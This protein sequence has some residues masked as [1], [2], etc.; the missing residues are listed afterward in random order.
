MGTNPQTGLNG[1]ARYL[2]SD[3]GVPCEGKVW[4]LHPVKGIIQS[5]FPNLMA[6]DIAQTQDS[7][8]PRQV[9]NFNTHEPKK[10]S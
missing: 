7:V 4:P 8:F 10:I 5:R 1:Q 2:W 3:F 9:S 6:E